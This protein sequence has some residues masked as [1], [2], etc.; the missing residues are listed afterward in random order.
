MSLMYGQRAKKVKNLTFQNRDVAGETDVEKLCLEVDALRQTLVERTRECEKLKDN[1][2]SVAEENETLR[3]KMNVL[4]RI[5]RMEIEQLET[6][7]NEVIFGLQK[8]LAETRLEFYRLQTILDDYR[9]EINRL[10]LKLLAG[11]DEKDKMAKMIQEMESEMFLKEEEL[12]AVRDEIQKLKDSRQKAQDE[13]EGLHEK[14]EN[15]LQTNQASKVKF[16]VENDD[17]N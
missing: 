7:L 3:Q 8:E 6:Q 13:I 14:L 5:N 16:G 9:T 4:E 10:K 11:E 1:D 15:A 2:A 17:L 12:L